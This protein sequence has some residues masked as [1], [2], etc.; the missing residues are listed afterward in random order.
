MEEERLL[1]M[2]RSMLE[3][4]SIINREL[5]IINTAA[6]PKFEQYRELFSN[7]LC[8]NEE[9]A[10]NGLGL[11]KTAMKTTLI[12]ILKIGENKA[13]ELIQYFIR[14]KHISVIKVGRKQ[15]LYINNEKNHKLT[16]PEFYSG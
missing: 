11:S 13:D 14:K 5:L 10:L 4:L 2:K 9:E 7:Y 12:E 16:N 3:T 8:D 6:I 15:I 1:I